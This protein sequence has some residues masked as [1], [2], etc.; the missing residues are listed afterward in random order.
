[1]NLSILLLFLPATAC[2]FWILMNFFVSRQTSTFWILTLLSADLMLFFVADAIYATPGMSPDVVVYSHLIT[3]FTGPCVIPLIWMYFDRLR[4]HRHYRS[5]QYFWILVPVSL[6]FAALALTSVIG[7][8]AVADFLADLYANGPSVASNY[9]GQ[10]VYYYYLWASVSFRV[11]VGV[12]LAVALVY[13]LVYLFRHKI[14][15]VNIINFF[16]NGESVRVLE[17]Q[18]YNMIIPGL[19]VLSKV[20]IF[21]NV[22]EA[23]P[24]VAIVQS[25]FVTAGFFIFLLCGLF[26]E[27]EKI[28]LV[29]ARHVMLYNYNS[30]FKGPIIE[31]MMEELLEEA[32]QDALLRL[33]EKVGETLQLESLSPGE[34]AAVKEKLF[35]TVAGSWDDSLLARFQS[36]MVNE[37]LFLQPSLSLQDVAERLHTNKT[38]IS[39]LVNNTFNLGFPELLNTL[40]IDYAE[41]YLLNHRDAKQNEVAKACGFLSA[42]SFNNVFK[43]ITGVTPKVWLLSSYDKNNA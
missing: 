1:M 22:L 35:T 30:A 38:Y 39:K 24:W 8:S 27:K 26:G 42:S 3:L 20:V 4:W 29:Q 17:L 5:S 13:F 12:E 41:Q 33:R 40:R 31:I 7:K 34:I 23:H 32:E 37:Q 2:L 15:I 16:R 36:L 14:R 11:V 19:F 9:K 21:K 28:N 43:K 6:L 25:L 10:L 18:L